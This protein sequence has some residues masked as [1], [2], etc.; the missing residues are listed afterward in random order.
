ME[1]RD[2]LCLET[3]TTED[4]IDVL[5]KFIEK[6]RYRKCVSEE[7]IVSG[8]DMEL[9]TRSSF[10]V[11]VLYLFYLSVCSYTGHVCYI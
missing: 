5:K 9:V 7:S 11:Q 3:G 8:Y 10:V 1:D 2:L 6:V 4:V